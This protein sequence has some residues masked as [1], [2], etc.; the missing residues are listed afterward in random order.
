[1]LAYVD[2]MI[3][4]ACVMLLLSMLITIVVQWLSAVLNLRGRAL[5]WGVTRVIEHAL[6]GLKANAEGIAE[7]VLKHRAVSHD[8]RMATAIRSDELVR[9]LDALAKDGDQSLDAAIKDAA[10][11]WEKVYA[12]M[13]LKEIEA[14]FPEDT[15]KAKALV[16]HLKAKARKDMGDLKAWFD[17]TM[18]RTSERFVMWTRWATIIAAFILSFAMRV[19]TIDLIQKIST[20][21]ELRARLVQSADATIKLADEYALKDA[22]S[23]PMA[24]R[25]IEAALKEKGEI[26]PDAPVPGDLVLRDRGTQWI[27]AHVTKPEDQAAIQALYEK[28]YD[29]G[30]KERT[31]DLAARAWQVKGQLVDT[32]L[33]LMPE[34]SALSFLDWL[35][36]GHHFVGVLMTTLLL[37]LGAPFW[38]NLLR[39]LGN[40]RPI[41]AGKVD[42]S[43]GKKGAGS[44]S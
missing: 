7:K 21:P 44:K 30:A 10:A 4:F 28:K 13:P 34:G 39:Q 11:G 40:L 14:F 23:G 18:D 8:G 19:D 20:T 31:K 37:S 36:Q 5:L 6:P 16:D 33:V 17:T 22:N 24:S 41:L 35:K 42:E 3:G 27:A 38:F 32:E 29:E 25:A 2:T 9:I 15:K 1:M 26:K 12:E 43:E